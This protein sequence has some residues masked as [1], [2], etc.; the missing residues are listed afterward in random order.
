MANIGIIRIANHYGYDSQSRQ[1]VEEMAE[2][3]QAINKFWRNELDYGRNDFVDV[4]LNSES[5]RNIVEEIG[6][7][8]ICLEEIKY[9]LACGSK[10]EW[11]KE[12][13]IERELGRIKTRG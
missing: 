9:L 4:P 3:T 5:E 11:S 2:L 7:V 8:E 6:D 13:K 1:L 12:Y 10:V